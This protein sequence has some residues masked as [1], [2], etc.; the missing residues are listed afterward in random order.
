[1]P[2]CIHASE[3]KNPFDFFRIFRKINTAQALSQQY[4]V[5]VTNPPYRGMTDCNKTL[6]KSLI[7]STTFE[8]M[9][10]FGSNAFDSGDVGTVVQTAYLLLY[11][12]EFDFPR[13]CQRMFAKSA[14]G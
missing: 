3:G 6:R 7:T 12:F 14:S 13:A 10:I 9:L 2:D 1:M 11:A 8:N 4:D 5:V